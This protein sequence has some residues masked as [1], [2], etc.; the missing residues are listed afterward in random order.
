MKSI[1]LE[2]SLDSLESAI[3]A[4]RGGTHRVELCDNLAE[5]GTTPSR[6]TIELVRK[7][8]TIGLQVMIH[9][10]GGD[11]CYS[12]PE[13]DTMKKD[14]ADAKQLGADGVVFGILKKDRTVD[15]ERT[16]ILV[17]LAKPMSTTFHRAFDIASDPLRSLEEI[18]SAGCD[19]LLTSGQRRTAEEGI[20]LIAKL[21]KH[22]GDRII[23]IPGCGINS[24]NVKNILDKTG[25][26]EIHIGTAATSRVGSHHIV[27]EQKVKMLM[28]II[29]GRR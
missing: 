1:L 29:S 13:F 16:K 17:D 27:D 6:K 15:K 2:I 20:P 28:Q 14:I 19:R 9:P 11:F 3:A 21:I 7:K 4:E 23:I 22:A 18:I 24:L 5:G 25:A 8:I 12:D 10:H 26:T